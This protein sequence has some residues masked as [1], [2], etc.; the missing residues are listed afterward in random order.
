MGGHRGHVVDSNFPA[1]LQLDK[2]A[3][4]HRTSETSAQLDVQSSTPE[5]FVSVFVRQVHPVHQNA[6]QLFEVLLL[7][8][9]GATKGLDGE[10]GDAA[11]ILS[12]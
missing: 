6:A 10:R 9:V 2:F 3:E 11:I 4:Y 7:K 1:L 12:A 8:V 5:I